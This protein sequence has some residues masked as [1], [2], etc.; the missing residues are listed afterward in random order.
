MVNEL[1][2]RAKEAS[3]A[4]AD[5]KFKDD[6]LINNVKIPK[7]NSGQFFRSLAK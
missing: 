1:G 7:I 6:P 2:P 3:H 4:C 5:L